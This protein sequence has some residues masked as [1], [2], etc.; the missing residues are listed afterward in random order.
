MVTSPDNR[1]GEVVVVCWPARLFWW[2]NMAQL[3]SWLITRSIIDSERACSDDSERA[4]SNACLEHARL[5][6]LELILL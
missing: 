3:L 6:V 5:I 1:E 4:C 2:T